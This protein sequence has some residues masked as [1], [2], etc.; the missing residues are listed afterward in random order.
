MKQTPPNGPPTVLL[1]F[2]DRLQD[3]H[4]DQWSLQKEGRWRSI[5]KFVILRC[6]MNKIRGERVT[7]GPGTRS[8]S[9]DVSF[10]DR[11]EVANRETVQR[12]DENLNFDSHRWNTHSI[13]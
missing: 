10:G 6:D 1:S 12:P 7:G 3:S 2:V 8:S 11:I 5:T 9:M 4:S 13:V